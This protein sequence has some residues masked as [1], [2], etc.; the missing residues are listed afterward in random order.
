MLNK[1]E[2]IRLSNTPIIKDFEN[3]ED[4]FN[5][6]YVSED[7]QK[8]IQ[9][10]YADYE[11][12]NYEGYSTVFFFNRKDGKYYENYGS[13]C[14]CYGLENQWNPEEIVFKELEKRFNNLF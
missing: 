13:H 8:D 7:I 9:I 12:E 4:V 10:I 11:C 14:S 6:F 2:Q 3:A 1:F 5:N